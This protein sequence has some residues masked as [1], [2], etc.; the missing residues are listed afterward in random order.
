MPT[1]ICS[2]FIMQ[3]F[4]FPYSLWMR[5]FIVLVSVWRRALHPALPPYFILSTASSNAAMDPSLSDTPMWNCCQA[6]WIDGR[7]DAF[8]SPEHKLHGATSAHPHLNAS[9][10]I[11]VDASLVGAG[12]VPPSLPPDGQTPIWDNLSFP[13]QLFGSLSGISCAQTGTEAGLLRLEGWCS[14]T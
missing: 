12:L 8:E 5:L 4:Y 13:V 6:A 9:F 10:S 7:G 11:A 3:R 14:T 2:L 1:L